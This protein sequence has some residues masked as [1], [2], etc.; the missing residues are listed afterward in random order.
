M[1][2]KVSRN[3]N[4]YSIKLVAATGTLIDYVEKVII[5]YI[6]YV[7]AAI[8][9]YLFFIE[10]LFDTHLYLWSRVFLNILYCYFCYCLYGSI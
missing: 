5:L 4:V 6:C 3:K 9:E 2:D 1:E 8:S 10:K 7:I